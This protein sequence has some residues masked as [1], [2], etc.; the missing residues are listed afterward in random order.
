MS[1]TWSPNEIQTHG[2]SMQPLQVG[3][4]YGPFRLRERRAESQAQEAH[5]TPDQVGMELVQDGLKR[6]SRVG[7]WGPE[8]GTVGQ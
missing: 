4:V 3:N 1:T 6:P 5:A 7:A 2:K 8:V